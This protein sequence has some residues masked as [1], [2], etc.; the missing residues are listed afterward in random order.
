[1]KDK[2]VT[3]ILEN[4]INDDL[5]WTLQKNIFN[6]EIEYH[7]ECTLSDGSTAEISIELDENQKFKHSNIMVI[8][9]KNLISGHLYIH[10]LENPKVNEIGKLI[11]IKNIKSTI[12]LKASTQDQVLSD[13]ISSIPSKSAARDKKISD[14]IGTSIP[15]KSECEIKLLD[16][17]DVK[18]KKTKITKIIDILFG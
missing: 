18:A 9:N 2:L 10:L 17:P 15:P 3:A 13:I 11:F 7:F 6:T 12:T 5:N 4:T 16:A 14:I 8:R 1:M